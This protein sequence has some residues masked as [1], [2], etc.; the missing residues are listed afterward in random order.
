[1]LAADVRPGDS[2]VVGPTET[3]DDDLYAFGSA[4]ALVRTYR[5]PSAPVPEV[6]ASPQLRVA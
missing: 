4:M 2:I 3:V 1:M 6:I 5:G